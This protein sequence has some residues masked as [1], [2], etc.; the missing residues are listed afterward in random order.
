MSS[1]R[2]RQVNHTIRRELSDLLAREVS[3]PRISGIFSVTEV[4]VSPD[5]MQ[6]KVFVSVMGSE[7]EK[8]EMFAGLESASDFLRRELSKRIRLRRIPKLI[9]TRDDSLE[10]GG[11]LLQL[12]DQSAIDNPDP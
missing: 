1:R 3:D 2:Q 8:A 7:Q 6:A 4:D 5:L 12:I 11:R 10:K 9:F